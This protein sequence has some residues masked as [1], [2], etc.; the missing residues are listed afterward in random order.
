MDNAQIQEKDIRAAKNNLIASLVVP[1]SYQALDKFESSFANKVVDNQ[2]TVTQKVKSKLNLKTFGVDE[3]A[4]ITVSVTI[5]GS[6]LPDGVRSRSFQTI[7][8]AIAQLSDFSRQHVARARVEIEHN[9]YDLLFTVA[10]EEKL[11]SK[12]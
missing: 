12:K 1:A 2:H 9:E 11:L 3:V 5:A 4:E 8:N 10:A 7:N 6:K